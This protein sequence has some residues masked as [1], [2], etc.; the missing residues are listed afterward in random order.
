M[1]ER[2]YV[3]L[4]VQCKCDSGRTHWFAVPVAAGCF[5]ALACPVFATVT[6]SACEYV[7]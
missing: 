5:L 3:I 6:V 2:S 1:S 4:N 7:C